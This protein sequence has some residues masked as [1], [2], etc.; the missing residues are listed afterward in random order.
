MHSYCVH[1]CSV[2]ALTFSSVF[3]HFWAAQ[4]HTHTHTLRKCSFE[5]IQLLFV[6]WLNFFYCRFFRSVL[7]ATR[8][9]RTAF[10]SIKT[11]NNNSSSNIHI[12][13]LIREWVGA[14]FGLA[15]S[16]YDYF[17]NFVVNV[18]KRWPLVWLSVCSFSPRLLP[19]SV[20]AIRRGLQSGSRLLL[21]FHSVRGRFTM[22]W[23]PVALASD[24]LLTHLLIPFALI[25]EPIGHFH[26][27]WHETTSLQTQCMLQ[28]NRCRARSLL[29]SFFSSTNKNNI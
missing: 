10:S 14:K 15:S 13:L 20:D 8:K 26:E 16:D 18:F 5:H 7:C 24:L 12:L 6:V 4:T 29:F 9:S 19:G 11:N 23:L 21:A 25:P 1:V 17:Y 2:T 3:V 22:P 27:Q 28:M